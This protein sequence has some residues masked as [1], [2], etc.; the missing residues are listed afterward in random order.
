MV[1]YKDF[2]KETKD[3]LT[4]NT[5]EG[6]APPLGA[7]KDGEKAQPKKG[8]FNEV[9]WKVES[10]LKAT[11][12]N[13]IVI[14]PVGDIK[15]VTANVEFVVP[16]VDGLK[17]KLAA[18]PSE[19]PKPTITYEFGN[20]KVEVSTNACNTV[21]GY[22]VTYEDKQKAYNA[23]VKLDAKKVSVEASVPVAAGIEGGVQVDYNLSDKSVAWG[24]GARYQCCKNT[25]FNL[26][27][28][29]AAKFTLGATTVIPGF[30]L[31]GKNVTGAVQIDF[32]RANN[33]VDVVAGIAGQVPMCPLNSSFKF[34]VNKSLAISFSHFAEIL[35]WKIASSFD[36]KEKKLGVVFT[37]E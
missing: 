29:N 37:R 34:K 17:G 27:T 32:A 30:Q 23:I 20:R 35:G 9:I 19:C 26:T 10:K 24:G 36:V 6:K 5:A 7:A 2:N 15:G 14:N 4:K 16:Q 12:E 21:Q 3:L 22:E 1:F 11:K 8:Q 18:K 28:A 31:A 13:P 25:V 33:A